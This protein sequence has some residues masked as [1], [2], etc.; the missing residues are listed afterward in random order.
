REDLERREDDPDDDGG[1]VPPAARDGHP[2][3]DGDAEEGAQ[4]SQ[5]EH[6]TLPIESS[7]A[8][9][10]P[11]RP[12]RTAVVPRSGAMVGVISRSLG[13]PP[14]RRSGSRS[15]APAPRTRAPPAPDRP[16]RTPASRA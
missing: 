12:P 8:A 1:H 13:G 4:E 3:Q 11:A 15:G 5:A 10:A 6:V 7:S 16:S 2:K 9:H 14:A